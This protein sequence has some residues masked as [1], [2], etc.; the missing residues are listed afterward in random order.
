MKKKALP[1]LV[2][3]ALIV[4]I[5]AITGISALIKK[6]TPSKERQELREYYNLTS[7]DQVAIILN[8]EVIETTA[9][10]IGD[11]VYIDYQFVHDSL[12]PRFYW[13]ANENIL[14][15]AT[16]RDLISA[17]ADSNSYLVTK[18]SIDY[19]RPIVKATSDSAYIDLDFVKEYS[20]FTYEYFSDPNRIIVYNTWG[21]YEVATV[22]RN[23]HIR[24]KGGI[25]SPILADVKEKDQLCVLEVGDNWTKVMTNDGVVG[26]V[27]GKRL[28]GTTED[29]R[30]SD[31]EPE[32]FAH[33]T[34]DFEICMAWHQMTTRAVNSDVASVL[35]ST[36]GINVIS[37][38]WFYLNDNNGGIADL[39]STDYVNY[40]HSQGVEVWALVSNLENSDVDTTYVLTHTSTRQNLVNQ[41]VSVAIQYNL[42]GI[43]LDFE[44]LNREE[45]GDAYIQ[46]VRELSIKCENNGIVLSI[47]NYVP[48]SYTS[49]Y[50]RSEQANFADYVVIMGY[51][52]HYAGSDEGSVSS[53]GWVRQG[54]IDTLAEV[55][56]NQVILGMPFYTRV[57]ALTPDEEAGD[58][59]DIDANI[60]Y[61]VSSQVYG[62]RSA[63]NLLAN[64]GVEKQ[65]LEDSGQN[66]AEFE[67]E[68]ITYKVWLEDSASAEARLKLMDEYELAGAS[69]WKLGFETSDVWDTIIKYIN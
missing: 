55:P 32:V 4:I 10:M 37:P 1:V 24:V 18:S 68:G 60:L 35:A 40:C 33:I 53:L 6:Y 8:N 3:C 54:V 30:S 41:I 63:S 45:V 61:S 69:F 52:E 29:T 21:N 23:T 65:W 20:D 56:A 46:F 42:D 62:M 66:Y 50:N 36:K 5:V 31:Y 17:E 26:Y 39:G 43:N 9:K 13:D 47:D 67:S 15:Y 12:N 48:T 2:V 64:Y 49:F 59:D 51:D 11:H 44:A 22:R 28:S 16:A 57:W 19:G 38:T 34:K 27:Q 25:K 7:E 58:N 14:L